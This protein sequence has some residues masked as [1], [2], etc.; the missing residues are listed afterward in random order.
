[1]DGSPVLETEEGLA[2]KF[3]LN[4]AKDYRIMNDLNIMVKAV[5]KLGRKPNNPDNQIFNNG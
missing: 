4:Y 2:E 3:N 5:R 1:L